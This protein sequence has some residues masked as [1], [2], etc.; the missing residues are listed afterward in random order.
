M[1]NSSKSQ[2]FSQNLWNV[3]IICCIINKNKAAKLEKKQP[4]LKE[5]QRPVTWQCF[6]KPIK[7][8]ERLIVAG[9][10]RQH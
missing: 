1:K 3:D 7:L 5:N 10:L 4:P 9:E 8:L 6:I 2:W